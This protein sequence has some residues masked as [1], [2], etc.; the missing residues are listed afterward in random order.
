MT[1]N[2]F[3]SNNISILHLAR[4]GRLKEDE[5]RMYFQQLITAVDYCHSRGVYH[6]D[7]KPE[8]L[9]LDAN[10]MLKISDF[11]L[12]ALPQQ[13]QVSIGCVL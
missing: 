4:S 13:V 6:R 12:S 3:C 2:E 7:L 5:A 8:N 11:G 1:S 10:G 9:L